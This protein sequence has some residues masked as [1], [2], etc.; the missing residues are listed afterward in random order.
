MKYLALLFLSMLTACTT[1]KKDDEKFLKGT[2]ATCLSITEVMQA[3]N[4]NMDK[5]TD[6]QKQVVLE[7]A[8]SV[9]PICGAEIMPEPDDVNQLILNRAY[10]KLLEAGL[11]QPEN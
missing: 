5:L 9:A 2:A 4:R 6:K 8:R 10:T 7:S 1:I 3:A 11:K